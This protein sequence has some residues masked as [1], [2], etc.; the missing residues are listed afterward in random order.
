MQYQKVSCQIWYDEKFTKLDQDARYLW[1][2]LVTCPHKNV[3]GMFV[4]PKG[5]I[6]EDTGMTEGA[7]ARAWQGVTESAMI[8][9]DENARTIWI[10]NHFRHNPIYGPNQAK[11]AKVELD[12]LPKTS[13]FSEYNEHLKELGGSYTFL[14]EHIEK[15][16]LNTQAHKGGNGIADGIQ[17]GEKKPAEGATD[18]IPDTIPDGMPD[19]M[20]DT[21]RDGLS[22]AHARNNHNNNITVTDTYIIGDTI[23]LP[24]THPDTHPATDDR[25]PGVE[26]DAAEIVKLYRQIVKPH[27]ISD[28]TLFEAR[29]H[30]KRILCDKASGLFVAREG[31]EP[32]RA[33][34][35][36]LIRAVRNCASEFE[37][38]GQDRE[39]ACRARN[40]FGMKGQSQWQG[41][42]AEDWQPPA[43]VRF[44]ADGPK[45][46][47]T[48]AHNGLDDLYKQA[49]QSGSCEVRI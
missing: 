40:F 35:D 24:L 28:P 4:L 31:Q 23:P 26:E 46:N 36:D 2:Y 12:T 11:A 21:M 18:T 20:P 39:Y 33:T 27:P 34:K 42:A 30:V 3:L 29:R 22:R 25:T 47:G 48:P 10:R 6:R 32:R 41:Y 1:L 45:K 7:F 19:T 9:Y 38:T 16:R 44:V 13:L 17:E 14:S 49:A 37:I 15:T 8:L 43:R 5:Y